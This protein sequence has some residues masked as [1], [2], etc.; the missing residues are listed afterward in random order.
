LI[1]GNDVVETFAH[2]EKHDLKG[3]P[4]KVLDKYLINNHVTFSQVFNLIS[5]MILKMINKTDYS[6]EVNAISQRIN[7]L[8][9]KS[10]KDREVLQE[11]SESDSC[12][13]KE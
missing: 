2:F 7:E 9:A 5:G 11:E 8:K 1:E 4:P 6:A 10:I 12:V 13:N 3:M